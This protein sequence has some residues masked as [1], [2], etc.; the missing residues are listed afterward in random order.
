MKDI[1]INFLQRLVSRKF[2][3]AATA[4]TIVLLDGLGVA[5]FDQ[6]VV[7]A[8]TAILV[9]WMGVQGLKDMS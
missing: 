4:M 2:L 7:L 3:V 6:E 5:E 1:L 9:V 8:A